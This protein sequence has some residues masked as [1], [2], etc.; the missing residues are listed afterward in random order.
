[1]AF[2]C[3][4]KK[5]MHTFTCIINVIILLNQHRNC[6]N[7]PCLRMHK[8]RSPAE[9]QEL[10]KILPLKFGV[11]QNIAIMLHSLPGI[12]LSNFCIPGPFSLILFQ[13]ISH[14]FLMLI[15]IMYIYHALINALSAHM[16]HINL[17]ML[18]YAHVTQTTVS[19]KQPT[20]STV[21]YTHLT[22]PTKIGV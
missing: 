6:G 14:L 10:S 22:L 12:V 16:I 19:P 17:N 5:E 21:S 4:T 8:W 7:C 15:I 20:Q 13:V 1:M 11:G 2:I 18:C 9:N 3:N